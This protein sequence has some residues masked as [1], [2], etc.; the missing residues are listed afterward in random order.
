MERAFCRCQPRPHTDRGD[1]Q[2]YIR[3]EDDMKTPEPF[4]QRMVVTDAVR[5]GTESISCK[6]EGPIAE[7]MRQILTALGEDP[8]REGLLRT[9]LRAQKALQF[10][11]SGYTTDLD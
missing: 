10:L 7:H 6:E 1:A 3:V 9:P 4:D 5:D 8:R 2:E 11:T